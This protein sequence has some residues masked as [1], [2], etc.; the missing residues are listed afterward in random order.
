MQSRPAGSSKPLC[1]RVSCP[2]PGTP[3][4]SRPRQSSSGF[5]NGRVWCRRLDSLACLP[6][7]AL[8][9]KSVQPEFKIRNSF[10]ILS[11]L[12]D[13]GLG[14]SESVPC[15]RNVHKTRRFVNMNRSEG[16]AWVYRPFGGVL[17]YGN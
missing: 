17:V 3:R 4:P 15:G 8:K 14:L 5:H 2:A 6:L 7:H 11:E 10:G 16:A 12:I 1:D 13:V 9:E